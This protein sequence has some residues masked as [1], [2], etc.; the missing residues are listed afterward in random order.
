[1]RQRLRT[2]ASPRRLRIRIALILLIAAARIAIPIWLAPQGP[3]GPSQPAGFTGNT[4]KPPAL[5][6]WDASGWT[7]SSI[8]YA[9]DHGSVLRT[10]VITRQCATTCTYYL[11]RSIQDPT[12]GAVSYLKGQLVSRSDGWHINWPHTTSICGGTPTAPIYW[13]QQV[14][15]IMVFGHDGP[16]AQAHETSYSYTPRCGYGKAT[17]TWLGTFQPPV[18]R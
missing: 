1:M 13:S 7:A 10:W 16:F 17:T 12:G 9:G 5:G 4:T 2:P 6:L 3:P 18:Q 8:G 11:T 15:W 14:T